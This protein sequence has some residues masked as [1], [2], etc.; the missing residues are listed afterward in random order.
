MAKIIAIGIGL[1]LAIT[2]I[3]YALIADMHRLATAA[4]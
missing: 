3:A 4:L 2:A 1:K